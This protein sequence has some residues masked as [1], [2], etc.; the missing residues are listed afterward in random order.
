MLA[1]GDVLVGDVVLTLRAALLS[2]MYAITAT[3]PRRTLA[4]RQE[5]ALAAEAMAVALAQPGRDAGRKRPDA[6]S[7]FCQGL[8]DE[9]RAAGLGYCQEVRAEKSARGFA[10]DGQGHVV[11]EELTEDERDAKNEAAI[12]ALRSSNEVLTSIHPRCP[13]RM[14]S[15]CYELRWPAPND[16]DLLRHG[17]LSLARH[18]GLL[19]LGINRDKG[20]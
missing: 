15:L 18:Y 6:L 5:A 12:L 2:P 8:R 13:R 17:L 7:L 3:D 4:D 1:K 19:D 14:V 16:E 10:V 20:L 11:P 9:C